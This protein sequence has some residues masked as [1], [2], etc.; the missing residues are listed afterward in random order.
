MGALHDGH[1]SLVERALAECD[2]VVVSVFV[3][4]TQFAAGEDL[5]RYPR[6]PDADLRSLAGLGVHAV[7]MPSSEA[8][9]R[10]D[11]ATRVHI[12]GPLGSRLE[13]AARPGHFDGVALVV[14]KLFAAARP[15]RAYFGAKDAQQCAVVRRL[16]ADLDSGVLV[17]VCPTVR[18]HDGLALSSRNAY[19][20][21]G[22]RARALA[23]PRALA[24]A[25]ERFDAG[26]RDAALLS[27]GGRELLEA[28]G[29]AVD[30]AAIVDPDLFLDVSE[31]GLGCVFVIAA[32]MNAA[33]LID[34]LRLGVDAAPRVPGPA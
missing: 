23:I 29:L 21:A 31:A 14:T 6:T 18:D 34:S 3:N 11:S 25:A 19:L 15:D 8:M 12:E 28:E 13:A 24:Y 1:R 32:R 10:E 17:V 7:F 33:R 9:Y 27:S 22:D 16:A 4:P 30:Y 2:R 5:E 20:D 26:E